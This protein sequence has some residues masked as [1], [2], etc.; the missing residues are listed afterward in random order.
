MQW[1]SIQGQWRSTQ[2]M[3]GDQI[4]LEKWGRFLN[5]SLRIQKNSD[6]MTDLRFK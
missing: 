2:G 1:Q 3:H 6:L 5:K 4:F